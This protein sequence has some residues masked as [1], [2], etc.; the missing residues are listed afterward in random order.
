MNNEL[1]EALCFLIGQ[2]RENKEEISYLLDVAQS[3]L[4]NLDSP[5]FYEPPELVKFI[6]CD[7]EDL[8]NLANDLLSL[9]VLA[10]LVADQMKKEEEKAHGPENCDQR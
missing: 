10:N 1:H 9:A 2:M 6:S 4:K 8:K 3:Q 7:T 5:D